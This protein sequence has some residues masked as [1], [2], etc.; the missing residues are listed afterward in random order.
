MIRVAVDAGR[1]PQQLARFDAAVRDRFWREYA[2]TAE[3]VLGREQRRHFAAQA[4]PD[5]QRWDELS[6]LT[7]E[8]DLAKAGEKV[9]GIRKVRQTKRGATRVY[10]PGGPEG[11][12][13]ATVRRTGG[14]RVL[15]DTGLLLRSI[16]MDGSGAV[17]RRGK[18]V[19]EFG[20]RVPYAKR[21]QFGGTFA[22]TPRQRGYLSHLLGRFFRGKSITTPARPFLGV[23]REGREELRRAARA[24]ARKVLRE[25]AG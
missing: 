19:L 1:L 4:G 22:V 23:G 14:A 6:D 21:H 10:G 9:G 5:G 8:L 18:R 15:T 12:R 24:K 20:T 25:A 16:T 13:S 11:Q 3:L 7:L 2:P 17:R